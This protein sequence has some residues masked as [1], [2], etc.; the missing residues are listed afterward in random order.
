MD[1]KPILPRCAL[2]EFEAGYAI[3]LTRLIK[4]VQFKI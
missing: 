2:S 4:G 3:R 1:G